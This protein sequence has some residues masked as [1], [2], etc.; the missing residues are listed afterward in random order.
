MLS[1]QSVLDY[2]LLIYLVHDPVGIV[3]HCRGKH[4]NLVQTRKVLQE[5]VGSR[6][7]HIIVFFILTLGLLKMNEGFVQIKN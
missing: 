4:N 6:S 1:I 2:P 7:N 5:L 3:R